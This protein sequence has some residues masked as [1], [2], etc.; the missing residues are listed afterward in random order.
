R[1]L[2]EGVNLMGLLTPQVGHEFENGQDM[3]AWF[4]KIGRERPLGLLLENRRPIQLIFPPPS[5]G[6]Q[7]PTKDE[8]G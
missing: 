8:E 3:Q 6:N 2:Y 5:L 1:F 7:W 4:L